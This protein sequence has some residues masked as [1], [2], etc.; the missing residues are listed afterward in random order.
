MGLAI[1]SDEFKDLK[2]PVWPFWDHCWRLGWHFGVT[3]GTIAT[4]GR[5]LC[6]TDAAGCELHAHQWH[7]AS[8]WSQHVSANFCWERRVGMASEV[9]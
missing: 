6:A 3:N 4:G 1:R 8:S 7:H 5:L 9:T 2:V